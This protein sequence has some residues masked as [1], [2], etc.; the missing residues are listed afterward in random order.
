SL[1]RV[2]LDEG[3][4][5]AVEAVEIGSGHWPHPSAHM[6]R[7]P[8]IRSSVSRKYRAV[9]P[10]SPAA[11]ETVMIDHIEIRTAR[12][13]ESLVFYADALAPLG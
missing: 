3:E 4:E 10:L 11:K 1:R 12:L 2:A 7:N 9:G 5:P 6:H 8:P 13:A